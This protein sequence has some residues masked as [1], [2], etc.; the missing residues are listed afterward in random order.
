MFKSKKILA[1]ITARGGSKTLPKKN[2][3]DFNGKPL[4]FWTIDVA[5]KSKYI[6]RTILSTDSQ[7][8]V[9]TA[10][11]F[12]CEVPFLRPPE[13]ATDTSSSVEVILHALSIVEGFDYFVLLQPTS[14]LRNSNDI[15]NCIEL[16]LN[17][18]AF[19]SVSVCLMEKPL[20]YV[21]SLDDNRINF[22]VS[23]NLI[24]R[25]QD[26][27]KNY[28]LNGAIYVVNIESFLK[29]KKFIDETSVGFVMPSARSI[30][31]DNEL[32][33]CIAEYI[34]KEKKYLIN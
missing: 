23:N 26:A 7:E 12:N 29:Q 33:F 3:L 31:I 13:Y 6:D 27:F 20:N 30:D 14:P 11:L 15:D 34:F 5:Q 22:I 21:C 2:I 25:R 9:E 19:S 1:V 17:S 28:V 16:C 18:N 8:I 4:I 10:R 24:S 32:D